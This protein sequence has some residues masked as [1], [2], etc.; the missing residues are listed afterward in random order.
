MLLSFAIGLLLLASLPAAAQQ[1]E[2]NPTSQ[3]DLVGAL[4]PT[5]VNINAFMVDKSNSADTGPLDTPP[6]AS[7]HPK[8]LSAPVS[9]STLAA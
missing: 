3:A 4:L 2:A 6:A 7:S 8:P 5:V 1:A 9:S